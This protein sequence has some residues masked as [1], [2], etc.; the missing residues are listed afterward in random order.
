MIAIASVRRLLPRAFDKS[1]LGT[2]PCI[3]GYHGLRK[4]TTAERLIKTH[5]CLHMGELRLYQRVVRYVERLLR[6]QHG[7]QID[8]ALAQAL[9]GDVEGAPRARDHFTLQA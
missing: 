1:C 4:P 3:G 6:L 2:S 9:L 8:R 7:N 5:D